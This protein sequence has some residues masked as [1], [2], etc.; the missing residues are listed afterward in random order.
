MPG[1]AN[2]GSNKNRTLRVPSR[3]TQNPVSVSFDAA[4]FLFALMRL[5]DVNA[6]CDVGS[7]ILPVGHIGVGTNLELTVNSRVLV[8][9]EGHRLGSGC[10]VC[11]MLALVR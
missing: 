1:R 5:A 6:D 4:Y 9:L 10:F 7:M 8:D 2:A 3:Q 11:E